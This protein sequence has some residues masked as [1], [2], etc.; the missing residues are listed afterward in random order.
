MQRDMP[1]QSQGSMVHYTNFESNLFSVHWFLCSILFCSPFLCFD[2]RVL[3]LSFCNRLWYGQELNIFSVI[4]WLQ[5]ILI[6][7]N[8]LEEFVLNEG[9]SQVWSHN[10]GLF[11]FCYVSTVL[12]GPFHIV[13]SLLW[14]PSL[15]SV[16]TSLKFPLRPLTYLAAS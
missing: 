1:V 15:C 11:H 13:C 4:I 2:S 8:K 16:R 3:A 14:R 6:E 5:D 7:L 12:Y 10:N 9:F